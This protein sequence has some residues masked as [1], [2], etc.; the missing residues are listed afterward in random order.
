MRRTLGGLADRKRLLVGLLAAGTLALAAC[1][2]DGDSASGASS[3]GEAGGSGQDFCSTIR[4][5]MAASGT[6]GTDPQTARETVASLDPPAEIADAWGEYMT[7]MRAAEELDPEDPEAQA[8]YQRQVDSAN[9][10]S[11]VVN[12]YLTGE[13][14]ISDGSGAAGGAGGAPETTVGQ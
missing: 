8:E 2:G 13:C 14:G 3:E 4:E 7:L 1:G 10:A 12:N 11:L 6:E 9:E 5:L